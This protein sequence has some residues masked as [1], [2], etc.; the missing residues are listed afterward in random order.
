MKGKLTEEDARELYVIF[1]NEDFLGEFIPQY[2]LH[3]PLVKEK[4][5]H[6]PTE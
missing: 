2:R 5:D 6:V 3:C 1:D 4:C